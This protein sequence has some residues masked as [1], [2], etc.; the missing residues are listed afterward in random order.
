MGRKGRALICKKTMFSEFSLLRV[1]IFS[2][3][4]VSA[5]IY[6]R[7]YCVRRAFLDCGLISIKLKGFFAKFLVSV[8][9]SEPLIQPRS[10]GQQIGATW[11]RPLPAKHAPE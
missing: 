7:L 2:T 4:G 6:E 1:E 8:A 9:P 3:I 5:Q 10:D 11:P